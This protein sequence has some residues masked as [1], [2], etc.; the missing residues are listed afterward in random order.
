VRGERSAT[1]LTP[2]MDRLYRPRIPGL[3]DGHSD[4]EDR[5]SRD[6]AK[7]LVVLSLFPEFLRGR[8]SRRL[9]SGGEHGYELI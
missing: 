8:A 2:S 4:V 6:T 9:T 7:R 3:L 1:E 5:C